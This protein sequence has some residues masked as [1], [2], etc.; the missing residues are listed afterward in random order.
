MYIVE[1][2]FLSHDLQTVPTKTKSRSV[3][4]SLLSSLWHV[5]C[6]GNLR[7]WPLTTFVRV[8]M[9]RA[10]DGCSQKHHFYPSLLVH[11]HDLIAVTDVL[12]CFAMIL[13]RICFPKC[14]LTKCRAF[15]KPW[16]AFQ[17]TRG[18]LA[19]WDLFV[20]GST[21][22]AWHLWEKILIPL[23]RFLVGSIRAWGSWRVWTQLHL[24]LFCLLLRLQAES[25]EAL[26]NIATLVASLCGCM[27][28]AGCD[29]TICK[30]QMTLKAAA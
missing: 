14:E 30:S 24:V 18:L 29:V 16:C 17:R 15:W 1:D 10:H 20:F 28:H 26:R 22:L 25:C 8:A 6:F 7:F 4:N 13:Y 19:W 3:V 21:N 5:L 2:P 27:Q 11:M 12:T 23:Q 9:G